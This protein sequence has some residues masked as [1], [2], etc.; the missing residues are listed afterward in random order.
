MTATG[1]IGPNAIAG[2]INIIKRQKIHLLN[3][4]QPLCAVKKI[5]SLCGRAVSG[6]CSYAGRL[7]CLCDRPDAATSVALFQYSRRHPTQ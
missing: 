1:T 5:S 3:M 7:E 6:P 2:V 4:I